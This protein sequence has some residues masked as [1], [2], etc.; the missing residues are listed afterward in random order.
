MSTVG[1]TFTDMLNQTRVD[2]AKQLLNGGEIP[3]YRVG[4]LVGIANA[5]YF[6]RV[7]RK[8]TGVTPNE[9]RGKPV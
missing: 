6:I 4:E 8:Y 1:C 7:F 3:V 2:R 5:T 9:Y